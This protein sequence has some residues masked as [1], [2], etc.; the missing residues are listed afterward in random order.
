MFQKSEQKRGQR[1]FV[2]QKEQA[3]HVRAVHQI[4]VNL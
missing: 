4:I 2:D 1:K 3:T